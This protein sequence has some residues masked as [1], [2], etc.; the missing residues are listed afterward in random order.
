M[1]PANKKM[2]PMQGPM[3]ISRNFD[4][5]NVRNEVE[6]Y[7]NRNDMDMHELLFQNASTP[8]VG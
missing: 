1:D 6:I 7:G 5:E 4:E 8:G 2:T 3:D